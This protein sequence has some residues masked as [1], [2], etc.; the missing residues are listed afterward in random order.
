MTEYQLDVTAEQIVH[1][2]KDDLAAGR[3]QL[4]EIRAT[5]EYISEPV[6]NL[7]EAGLSEDA[8]V[9]SLAT[10]G[11][12]EVMPSGVED[13]W[14][15]RVRVEDVVGPHVPE[16]ESVP[17]LPEEI[18]LDVFDAEFVAPDRGTAYIALC[19]ETPKAKRAFDRIFSDLISDRHSG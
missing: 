9:T 6:A 11:I 2:L 17:D 10:V 1:W 12:L 4:L 7:E 15:L 3:R 13:S 19:A 5:R 8:E 16:D 14:V 18:E